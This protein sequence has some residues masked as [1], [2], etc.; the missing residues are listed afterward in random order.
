M[1]YVTIELDE[2]GR[3]ASVI[4]Q[5]KHIHPETNE[6]PHKGKRVIN[7]GVEQTHGGT[8]TTPSTPPSSGG[9]PG[10]ST[11]PPEG[12]DPCCIRDLGTG[13]VWCWC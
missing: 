2:K 7:I 13:K 3:I 8:P 1:A 12:T 5:G 6:K 9:T 10:S 11:P 4:R